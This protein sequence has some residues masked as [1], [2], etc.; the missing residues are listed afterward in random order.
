MCSFVG[1]ERQKV[2]FLALGH[3]WLPSYFVRFMMSMN[4]LLS[5][6]LEAHGPVVNLQLCSTSCPSLYLSPSLADP[7]TNEVGLEH[8]W[9]CRG[10]QTI[11]VEAMRDIVVRTNSWNFLS[12]AWEGV[13]GAL[14]GRDSSKLPPSLPPPLPPSLPVVLV[15]TYDLCC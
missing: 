12:E 6:M 5:R 8:M 7:C 2:F 15:N 14:P 3:Q 4:A 11:A 10:F 1:T 13:R 9:I